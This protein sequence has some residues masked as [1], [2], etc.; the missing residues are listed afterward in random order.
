MANKFK[1]LKSFVNKLIVD[2]EYLLREFQKL[3]ILNVDCVVS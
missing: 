2:F 3:S 1:P